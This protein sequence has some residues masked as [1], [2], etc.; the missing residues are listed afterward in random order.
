MRLF[1]WQGEEDAKISPIDSIKHH[2]QYLNAGFLAI[3]PGTGK[4]RSW[5]GG[6]EP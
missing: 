2:L 5:V 4:V 6:I 1:T 3:E